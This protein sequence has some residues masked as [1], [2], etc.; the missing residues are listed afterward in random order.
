M[1]S[2]TS[3]VKA[4]WPHWGA[5]FLLACLSVPTAGLAA[6]NAASYPSDVPAQ[7]RSLATMARSR[8]TFCEQ[9]PPAAPGTWLSLPTQCAWRG[10]LR[11][12]RWISDDS[13]PP[14]CI[15]A[16]AAWWHWRGA[17][18]RERMPWPIWNAAWRRQAILSPMPDESGTQRIVL[19]ARTNSGGWI[20]TEWRWTAPDRAATRAWEQQRWEQL[21]RA[22]KALGD[23]RDDAGLAPAPLQE[24]WARHVQGQPAERVGPTLAWQTGHQCLRLLAVDKRD[25]PELPLPYAREDSRLEQ[26]AATQVQLARGTPG[27]TWPAPFHLMLPSVPQ[28]RG[29]TYAAILRRGPLLIGRLWLPARNEQALLRARL[30][31]PL[32]APP[33]SAEETRAVSLLDR[34]MAA[35]AALWTS[36]HER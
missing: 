8:P 18:L 25:D 28:Q 7:V 15:G 14:A 17:I 9:Q 27:A 21:R 16:A 5:A 20:A 26:R 13:V 30:E 34:E 24:L 1:Y 35:L 36:D 10:G 22:V 6:P 3:P 11:M 12:Q 33:G 23:D 32:I 19:V 2:P 29:A 31:M 4:A